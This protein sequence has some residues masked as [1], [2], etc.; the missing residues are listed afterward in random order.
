MS[1]KRKKSQAFPPA[2]SYGGFFLSKAST[3]VLVDEQMPMMLAS[4][5]QAVG[6]QTT[7][8]LV[9]P[10]TLR[11]TPP[12]GKG[13]PLIECYLGCFERHELVGTHGNT[14]VPLKVLSSRTPC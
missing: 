4:S 8:P 10:P 14:H 12:W 5:L 11:I 2:I 13:D 1:Q 9:S 7:L 3:S 6:S